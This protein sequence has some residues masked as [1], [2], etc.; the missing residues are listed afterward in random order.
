MYLRRVGYATDGLWRRQ[1][2]RV[3]I[4]E[5]AI[6]DDSPT[7]RGDRG[8]ARVGE[9]PRAQG[10]AVILGV[11]DGVA[12]RRAILFIGLPNG[13]Q[14]DLHRLVAV[15]SI[16]LW[17]RIE[18][19]LV[20]LVPRRTCAGELAW[21]NTTEGDVCPFSRW[22]GRIDERLF[23]DAIG[24]HQFE[25]VAES[26]AQVDP[27]L[28]G[29]VLGDAPKV[30]DVGTALANLLGQGAI[31]AGLAV[32]PLGT[33][34]HL[35]AGLRGR[36]GI[37]QGQAVS[38]QLGVVQ[39]VGLGGANGLGPSGC[40]GALDLIRGDDTGVI[41]LAVRVVDVW[42]VRLDR[43]F[44]LLGQT[45]VGIGRRDHAQILGAQDRNRDF[46]GAG[47]ERADVHHDVGIV[48]RRVGVFGLFGRIPGALS[49]GRIVHILIDD[50]GAANFGAN[51]VSGPIFAQSHLE[52]ID[53]RVSLTLVAARARQAG[54]DLD[55][56]G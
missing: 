15:A 7:H 1:G 24:T 5:R 19:L 30:D 45:W 55:R 31:I 20:I 9:A 50:R 46:R 53:E 47:V 10:T 14:R 23:I 34:D 26:R 44:D 56:A 33:A 28:A 8:V 11:E 13:V 4:V 6:L 22:A 38:V 52:R 51:T 36:V 18:L 42:L 3:R 54:N 25:V 49:R 48:D 35:D 40:R 39:D 16:R 37:D 41:A 32:D 12:N 43:A 21:R 29:V 27:Q 17:F 2:D